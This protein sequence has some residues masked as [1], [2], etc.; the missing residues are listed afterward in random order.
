MEEVVFGKVIGL[1][2]IF[3][4]QLKMDLRQFTTPSGK[5]IE[6]NIVSSNYHMELTPRYISIVKRLMCLIQVIEFETRFRG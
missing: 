1:N 5:K 4:A 6:L 3:D 2:G